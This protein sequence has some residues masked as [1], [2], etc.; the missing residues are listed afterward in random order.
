MGRLC[1]PMQAP[2]IPRTRDWY[3]S[4]ASWRITV[5]GGYGAH[6]AVKY[7]FF[8][9]L[10]VSR[11]KFDR[12]SEFIPGYKVCGEHWR[13]VAV[14][15]VSKA[16]IYQ[17]A[18]VKLRADARA[19]PER[20]EGSGCNGHYEF[21]LIAGAKAKSVTNNLPILSVLGVRSIYFYHISSLVLFL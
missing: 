14:Q 20:S 18:G 4:S 10:R 16:E 3:F 7:K 9:A 13:S 8:L 21:V 17:G 5:Q 6:F 1:Y 11:Y 19:C 2:G 15:I 12:S